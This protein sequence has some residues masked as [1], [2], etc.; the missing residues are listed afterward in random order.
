MH[1]THNGP[2][3]GSVGTGNMAAFQLLTVRPELDGPGGLAE[4]PDG[5]VVVDGDAGDVFRVG[6]EAVDAHRRQV[7]VLRA[8]RLALLAA[9]PP[10]ALHDLVL[11][12]GQALEFL[13]QK[14]CSRNPDSPWRRSRGSNPRERSGRT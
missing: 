7:E 8:L 1:D 12:T 9:L 11:K 6:L 3:L 10:P 4:A 2:T 14:C 13:L 5:V